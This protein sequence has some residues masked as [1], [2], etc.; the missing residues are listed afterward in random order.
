M[1][2]LG[3]VF[4]KPLNRPKLVS[5]ANTDSV[6]STAAPVDQAKDV[7]TPT[8][9]QLGDSPSHPPEPLSKNEASP[10]DCE[11]VFVP[12]EISKTESSSELD[13][14]IHEFEKNYKQFSRR[15]I[16]ID[17]DLEAAFQTAHKQGD[18]HQNA[19]IFEINITTAI[20]A[21]EK[22]SSIAQGKW[23][24]QVGQF[25][26]KMYPMARLA[27]CLTAAVADVLLL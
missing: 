17:N 24:Y 15:Y 10:E 9:S 1:N 14:A 21:V 13:K 5:A 3:K 27:S 18:F 23:T 4:R 20:K 22:K 26:T 2:R 7:P 11:N 8:A 12:V 6:P 25:L 19:K 16:L